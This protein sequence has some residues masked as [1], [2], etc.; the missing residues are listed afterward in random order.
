MDKF[1]EKSTPLS[2]IDV[3]I[4][5]TN[6]RVEEVQLQET[7]KKIYASNCNERLMEPEQMAKL[8]YKPDKFAEAF[9][10]EKDPL[11]KL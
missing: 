7:M 1:Y 3:S 6:N 10:E 4:T 9:H 11:K 5:K 2:S 8:N